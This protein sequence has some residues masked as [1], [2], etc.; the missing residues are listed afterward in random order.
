MIKFDLN[1]HKKY[2][3]KKKESYINKNKEIKILELIFHFL[4]NIHISL[5]IF[6]F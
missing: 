3:N 6:K 1:V 2:L 5:F 4:S